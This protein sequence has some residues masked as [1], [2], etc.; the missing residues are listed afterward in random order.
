MKSSVLWGYDTAYSGRF[1]QRFGGTYCL[2][3]QD[4][5]VFLVLVNIHLPE[6][7]YGDWRIIVRWSLEKPDVRKETD[8][9]ASEPCPV[10]GDSSGIA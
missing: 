1:F 9:N 5:R 3:L 6:E 8:G 7:E 2:H 10:T 4:I